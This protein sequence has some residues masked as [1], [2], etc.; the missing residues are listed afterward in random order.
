MI[1]FNAAK[2]PHVLQR[3]EERVQ[4]MRETFKAVREA[5]Q[6]SMAQPAKTTKPRK[7]RR[8]KK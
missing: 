8:K 4:A 6:P 2:Q 7:N 3:K 5:S 1:D